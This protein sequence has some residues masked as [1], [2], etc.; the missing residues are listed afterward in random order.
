MLK[1]FFEYL[2]ERIF[3]G[4]YNLLSF[5]VIV[6]ESFLTNFPKGLQAVKKVLYKQI[7]FSGFEALRLTIQLGVLIGI[8]VVTQIASLIKGL[9][10]I[11]LLGKVI[12][13]AL[14]RE[15]MPIFMA[16][17]L[18]ARSGTA[19]TSELTLMKVNGEIKTLKAI[20]VD[21]IYY[22]VFPR[23]SA[24][25]ISTLTV[26]LV[27]SFFAVIT[28]SFVLFLFENVSFSDFFDAIFMNMGI[29]DF[30]LFVLKS[31]AFGLSIPLICT[32]YGLSIK[33]GVTEVPQMATKAVLSCFFYVFLI[34]VL[35]DFLVLVWQ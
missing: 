18:I 35:L 34:N 10:G 24:F 7:Y 12:S 23:I 14:V 19:I 22:L 8:V 25:V 17:I 31:L 11:N 6:I 2:F 5:L 28:G 26:T 1:D 32:F 27:A 33:R 21:P 15:V 16:I 4:I 13:I 3:G 9:G 29:F 30:I 20:G